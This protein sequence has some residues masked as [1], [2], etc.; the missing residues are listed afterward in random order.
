MEAGKDVFVEWPLESNFAKAK[1]LADFAKAHNVKTVTGYQGRFT[2]LVWKLKSL[3]AEGRIGKL[4]GSDFM[5]AAP[6]GTTMPSAVDY[7]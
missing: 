3:I 7:L 1:K 5:A 4:E 6:G 2:P